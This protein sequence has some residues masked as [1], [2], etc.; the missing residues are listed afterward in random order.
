MLCY[1][2]EEATS[3]G[4]TINNI[5]PIEFLVGKALFLSK[6]YLHSARCTDRAP[7]SPVFLLLSVRCALW[8]VSRITASPFLSFCQ[9]IAVFFLVMF[10]LGQAG[11]VFHALF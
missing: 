1:A 8:C 10:P 5:Y 4:I 7:S 3:E 2:Q 11:P 9:I 6:N